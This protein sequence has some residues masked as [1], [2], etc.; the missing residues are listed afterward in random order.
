VLL[1]VQ[2]KVWFQNQRSKI[3]RLQQRTD[4]SMTSHRSDDNSCLLSYQQQQQQQ[5]PG[6]STATVVK[7]T[8]YNFRKETEVGR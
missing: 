3:K 1:P 7:E 2:V 6:V 8:R 5:Q 4:D